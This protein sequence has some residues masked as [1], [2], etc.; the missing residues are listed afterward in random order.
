MTTGRG[1]SSPAR[2]RALLL[3]LI[4]L[5]TWLVAT[6]TESVTSDRGAPL[7]R[8][9]EQIRRSFRGLLE[10]AAAA[11]AFAL[12]TSTAEAFVAANSGN[13]AGRL[14]GVGIYFR[15]RD[16]FDWEGTPASLPP[17]LRSPSGRP[18]WRVV[19]QGVRT[20]LLAVA[21]PD[22]SG[23]C[24]ATTYVL[25]STLGDVRFE[26]LLPAGTRREGVEIVLWDSRTALPGGE[27]FTVVVSSADGTGLALLETGP[28]GGSGTGFPRSR[29]GVPLASVAFAV[30][31]AFAVPWRRIVVHGPGLA[32]ALVGIAAAR[33][34]LLAAH[35]PARLLPRELGSPTLYGSFKAWGLIASPADL[36]LTCVAI[37]LAFVAVARF[38]RVGF[39]SSR[40]VRGAV[41]LVVAT[42]ATLCVLAL[43]VSLARDSRLEVLGLGAALRSPGHL[44][45]LTAL[46]VLMLGTAEA[47][48]AGGVL[49]PRQD[50]AET[51]R[52]SRLAV[53]GALV[54]L[55]ALGS[56]TLTT[57]ADRL[58]LDRL[59]SEYRPQ[60]LDQNA[61]RG[62]A[63]RSAVGQAKWTL[64]TREEGLWDV[65]ELTRTLAYDL[66]V[67]GALFEAGYRSSLEVYDDT[68]RLVSHFGF[69]LPRPEREGCLVPVGDGEIEVLEEEFPLVTTVQHYLHAESDIVRGGETV[70]TVVAH[71]LDEP[72]NLP[73]LPGSR[74]FLA[75]LGPSAAGPVDPGPTPAY[76]LYSA[77]GVVRFSTLHRPPAWRVEFDWAA[78]EERTVAVEAEG[79]PH[80]ALPLIEL[81]RNHLLLVPD[82][83]IPERLGAFVRLFLVGLTVLAL[84]EL[85]R[86]SVVRGGIRSLLAGLRGSFYRKLAVTLLLVSVVPLVGLSLTL[87]GFI[88][89]RGET[90]LLD[91]AMGLV[92]V[93][94]QVVEDYAGVAP[95]G[96]DETAPV[97]TDHLLMWL[98]EIVGQEIHL[99]ENGLLRA[100]S[101]R[102]LFTSGLLLPRL[103]GEV[104]RRLL[105]E[106]RPPMI[107]LERIG[108]AEAHVAYAPVTLDDPSRKVVIAVPLVVEEQAM[109]RAVGRVVEL[110]LLTTVLLAGLLV[111]AAAVMART[112]ARPV[113]DLVGA[114]ARI[115]KGDY[116]TRLAART[117]DE[118]AHLVQGFNSMAASLEDQRADLERRR[119]YMQALLTN[120]T[121]GVV[122]LDRQGRIVTLNPTAEDL[123]ASPGGPPRPGRDLADEIGREN[124]LEPLAEALRAPFQPGEPEEVDLHAEDGSRRLRVVRVDLPDPAGGAGGTLVLVDDVTDLMRSNQLQ[125]WAEMARAIAH[126]IKNPLTPIQ[127]STEHLRRV[128]IDRGGTPSPEV[129]SCLDTVMKQVRALRE[130]ASEFSAYAKL[131]D[132]RTEPIDP[133]SF[134]EETV[135]PYRA[136]HPPG[137]SIVER[138]EDCPSAE[139][140]A[141]VLARAVVNLIENAFQSMPEGGTLTL[142]AAP[143]VDGTTVRMT[144][145]D[146]GT[147]LTPDVRERLFEPYFSTKSSGTGLGLAIVRRAV[148]AHGGRIEVESGLGRGTA[149]HLILP[150]DLSSSGAGTRTTE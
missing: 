44:A 124:T 122:S 144:V 139:I 12:D 149:F 100:S 66:W 109:E 19:R 51:A 75:A 88:E 29:T 27:P 57:A 80:F 23:R 84:V 123:L 39:T 13:L 125:A 41:Y 95:A 62:V 69:G 108:N 106:N 58:A 46:G 67:T 60:V 71:V 22:A 82:R 146:T 145:R 140:D 142:E 81:E 143:D 37:A 116:D 87:R 119:D 18:E 9:I 89:Q 117:E 121:T 127:L 24:A 2:T 104:Y 70:G 103:P 38:L 26:D 131:P 5:A 10:E 134:L 97:F 47:W 126:E 48:A 40:A 148:E 101:R 135:E 28:V 55:A 118:L 85:A 30:A 86:R 64:E 68:G 96:E 3:L 4:P 1:R 78:L 112:V 120:A 45:V 90:T 93:A 74:T 83:T 50:G 61:W 130:I 32:A 76:V 35:A 128:L 73:F 59:Q 49:R 141:R 54:V 147:G 105:Q 14:E 138:Y 16:Y 136:G 36:L 15:G 137:I 94:Q 92:L 52:P 56:V 77:A 115:A 11:A 79:E 42:L 20:R 111:V 91:S 65:P 7:P 34:F 33:W 150:V 98:R 17:A 132:L 31:L 113:R 99:Y 21:G 107:R 129:E 102:G 25:D 63:L 53:A 133:V 114:T 6:V 72:D 8:Q 43:C 110:L